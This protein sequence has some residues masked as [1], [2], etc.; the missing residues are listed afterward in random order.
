MNYQKISTKNSSEKFTRKAVWRHGFMAV[1]IDSER[2]DIIN[3]IVVIF[4]SISL[5]SV[6]DF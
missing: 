6:V 1:Y 3:E 5:P 2:F 4:F